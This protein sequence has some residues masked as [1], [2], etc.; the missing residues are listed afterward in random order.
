[1][2]PKAKAFAAHVAALCEERRIDIDYFD[3]G[4]HAWKE[5]RKIRIRPIRGERTYATAMHEIG[6]ILGKWQGRN[7]ILEETGAW[8][9]AR[10]N[11]LCW[12]AEMHNV[13]DRCLTSYIRASKPADLPRSLD[14][15]IHE[16]MQ[17]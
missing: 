17:F 16:L 2:T 3:G 5:D 7:E 6:H 14:H 15:P 13:M 11:A 4:D 1:M 12:T 9:W 8:A 10:Q